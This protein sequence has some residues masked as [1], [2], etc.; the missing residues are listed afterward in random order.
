MIRLALSISLDTLG[1]ITELIE[2]SEFGWFVNSILLTE[3]YRIT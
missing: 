3:G 2:T 1:R